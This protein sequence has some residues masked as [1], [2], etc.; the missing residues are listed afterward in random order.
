M[1]IV[2]PSVRGVPRW[3]A[4]RFHPLPG[5]PH[6]RSRPSFG[7]DRGFFHSSLGRERAEAAHLLGPPPQRRGLVS[8]WQQDRLRGLSELPQLRVSRPQ[9]P[10]R[11]DLHD[12]RRRPAPQEHN[13][14]FRN[15]GSAD[16]VW[17]P[18]GKKI[19]FLS[20]HAEGGEFGIG[21]ATMN[22]D[23]TARHFILH[24]PKEMHQPDWESIP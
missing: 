22:P 4:A 13:D 9:R 16:P 5:Q 17:S 18:D 19:L 20:A 3:E 21:L 1:S 10:P 8:R 15:G 11:R 14:N 23:G 6:R 2:V 12:G 24:N 7:G